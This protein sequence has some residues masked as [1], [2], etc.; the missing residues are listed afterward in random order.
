MFNHLMATKGLNAARG[1]T[2]DRTNVRIGI[3]AD[4][5]IEEVNEYLTAAIVNRLS[6]LE[7]VE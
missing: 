5:S 2:F 4:L 1:E 6:D 7:A 3:T